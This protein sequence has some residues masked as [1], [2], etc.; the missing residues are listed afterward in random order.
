MDTGAHDHYLP[1]AQPVVP[2]LGKIL[3]ELTLLDAAMPD[4]VDVSDPR[5]WG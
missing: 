2:Y 3:L 4:Y 5:G 1:M